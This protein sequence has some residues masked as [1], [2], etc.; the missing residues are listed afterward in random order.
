LHAVPEEGKMRD[1]SCLV[2]GEDAV[3]THERTGP[4]WETVGTAGILS[5]FFGTLFGSMFSPTGFFRQMR[6]D[7]G[8]LNPLIYGMI[9]GTLSTVV[10]IGW[11][12]LIVSFGDAVLDSP[13][14]PH[15]F[16]PSPE[17][18]ALMAIL[19]PIM[20]TIVAFIW[21]GIVHVLLRLFGGATHGFQ[22]SFRVVCYARSA[23]IWHIVPIFGP[24]IGSIWYVVLLVI[25]FTEAHETSMGRALAAVLI[26]LLAWV[27]IIV[28]VAVA[29][30]M[31]AY[32]LM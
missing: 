2:G 32:S 1:V 9:L 28:L 29:L 17:L 31:S 11:N 23:G 5:R 18:Y 15:M 7:G 13:S 16:T 3:T 19:S 30:M 22:A 10:P 12:L 27:G 25:G 14:T 20:V 26:P 8:Y 21:S 24:L 6:R 4:P